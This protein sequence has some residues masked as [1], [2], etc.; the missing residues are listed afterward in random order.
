MPNS[1]VS[2]HYPPKEVL[3]LAGINLLEIIS[4]WFCVPSD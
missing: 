3:S 4:V 1:M 2:M